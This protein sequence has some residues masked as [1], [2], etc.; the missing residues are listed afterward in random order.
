MLQN[1]DTISS[2]LYRAQRDHCT[3]G[4]WRI[5]LIIFIKREFSD[6]LSS[7]RVIL[8]EGRIEGKKD[9]ITSKNKNVGHSCSSCGTQEWNDKGKLN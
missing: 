1:G 5:V 9:G 8:T 4:T 2:A 6:Q 3:V 7:F